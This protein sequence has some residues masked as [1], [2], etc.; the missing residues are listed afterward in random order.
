[1]T[2]RQLAIKKPQN[3]N[4]FK[5]PHGKQNKKIERKH[6]K[7]LCISGFFFTNN[8]DLTFGQK[9]E[10]QMNIQRDKGNNV[11]IQAKDESRVQTYDN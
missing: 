6:K 8:A 10:F 7:Y 4:T 5:I 2:E 1:M 9:H 11:K 3:C